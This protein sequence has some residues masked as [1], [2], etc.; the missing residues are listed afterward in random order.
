MSSNE[1]KILTWG[2]RMIGIGGAAALKWRGP[3]R[4]NIILG[5]GRYHVII[6][7]N[8]ENWAWGERRYGRIGDQF[9]GTAN[10]Q[11]TPKKVLD[12][13][14]FVEVGGGVDWSLGLDSDGKAWTWG[15]NDRGQLGDGTNTTRYIPI[16]VSDT[17]EFQKISTGDKTCIGIDKDGKLWSWGSG[18]YGA[19][20]NGHAFTQTAYHIKTPTRMLVEDDFIDVSM[21]LNHGAAIDVNGDIWTWGYNTTG[22]LGHGNTTNNG[23]PTR[24][25]TSTKWSKVAC[26]RLHTLALDLEGNLWGWGRNNNGQLG[27]G[28]TVSSRTTPGQLNNG[29]KWTELSAGFNNSLGIDS[30]GDLWVWGN[31]SFGEL[32][33]G[34][35]VT[36]FI[37]S[38]ENLSGGRKYKAIGTGVYSS[39]AMDVDSNI[40]TTGY[41]AFG[42]LGVGDTT[43]RYVFTK[44]L[45]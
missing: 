12:E 32:G 14:D 42:Q 3:Q 9:T 43:N 16:L 7:R 35:G 6:I 11:T 34:D 8:N 37:R 28:L 18:T 22:Q 10:A 30:T 13:W 21:G 39:Y 25:V 27:L 23:T 44:V 5:V 29:Q 36:G 26:G 17:I 2:N 15:F 24:I 31:G 19:L 45:I 1:N 40:W 20:G 4:T 38:P 33:R 41:N